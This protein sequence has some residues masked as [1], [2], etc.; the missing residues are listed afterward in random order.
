MIDDFRHFKICWPACLLFHGVS[1]VTITIFLVLMK[2]EGDD[3]DI[4]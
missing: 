2:N 1:M 3:N 4:L